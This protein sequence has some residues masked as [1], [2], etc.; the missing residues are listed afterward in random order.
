MLERLLASFDSEYNQGVRG[1]VGS[2]LSTR[3]QLGLSPHAVEDLERR[4]RRTSNPRAEL[5]AIRAELLERASGAPSEAVCGTK[6]LRTQPRDARNTTEQPGSSPIAPAEFDTRIVKPSYH[7]TPLEVHIRSDPEQFPLIAT[8]DG[9]VLFAL[10]GPDVLPVFMSCV[11][12]FKW[13]LYSRDGAPRNARVLGML[14]ERLCFCVGNMRSGLEQVENEIEQNFGQYVMSM[15]VDEWPFKP[16]WNGQFREEEL[17]CFVSSCWRPRSMC[18]VW[19]EV[20]AVIASL[21]LD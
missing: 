11:E 9:F 19:E 3:P 18:A 15:K 17:E 12:R 14:R 4:M 7:S 6:R 8:F 1:A 10:G 16:A 13:L 20:H 21:P 5:A 2:Y